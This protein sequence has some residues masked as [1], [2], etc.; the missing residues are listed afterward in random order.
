MINFIIQILICAT[1]LIGSLIF[2]KLNLY[3]TGIWGM[4]MIYLSQESYATSEI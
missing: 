4:W 2:D 3:G 1:Q